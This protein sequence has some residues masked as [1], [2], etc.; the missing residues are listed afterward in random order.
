[1]DAFYQRAK[2]T[3]IRQSGTE[4]VA[5]HPGTRIEN[6]YW[7]YEWT[8]SECEAAG[9]L[10]DELKMFRIEN[11]TVSED[12]KYYITAQDLP[13]SI[14]SV[15]RTRKLVHPAERFSSCRRPSTFTIT[16]A[17]TSCDNLA[18][19]SRPDT[20]EQYDFFHH[21]EREWDTRSI[22]DSASASIPSPTLGI[23]AQRRSES[24]DWSYQP[25]EAIMPIKFSVHSNNDNGNAMAPKPE[26]CRP[27]Q[28]RDSLDLDRNGISLCNCK[29]TTTPRSGRS[30]SSTQKSFEVKEQRLGWWLVRRDSLD[31]HQPCGQPKTSRAKKNRT[32]KDRW[33]TLKAAIHRR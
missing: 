28:A 22:T 27:L 5:A 29:R 12:Y 31:L 24:G 26:C 3:T 19:T 11:A 16:S 8:T 25:D 13:S 1:M 15:E 7:R 17:S 14:H 30:Q 32:L 9:C 33:A 10:I 20:P 23:R 21:Y 4:D 6:V 18:D 2:G